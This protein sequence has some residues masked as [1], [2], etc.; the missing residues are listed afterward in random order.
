MVPTHA[1][2]LLLLGCLAAPL[3][4][5]ART[6]L[7]RLAE[8][9][10]EQAVPAEFV[11]TNDTLSALL[12]RTASPNKAVIFTTTRRGG[13][14]SGRQ[15]GSP[16]AAGMGPLAFLTSCAHPPFRS[17]PNKQPAGCRTTRRRSWR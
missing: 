1:S 2:L 3:A 8:A 6:P 16:D 10:Q 7:R 14:G 15:G 17:S 4:A 11:V 9:P 12:E 5:A 13:R